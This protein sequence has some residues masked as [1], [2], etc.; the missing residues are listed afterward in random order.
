M[1]AGDAWP[2]IAA[3]RGA[4]GLDGALTAKRGICSALSPK[5]RASNHG[6]PLAIAQISRLD[7]HIMSVHDPL[8]LTRAQWEIVE[9]AA[10]S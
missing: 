1:R 9:A 5:G 4:G 3:A 6:F 7:P 2:V 8:D 10:K